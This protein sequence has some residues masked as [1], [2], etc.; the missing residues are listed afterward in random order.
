MIAFS[1][2]PDVPLTIFLMALGTGIFSIITRD[3]IWALC[4]MVAILIFSILCVTYI[5]PWP[6]PDHCVCNCRGY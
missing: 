5:G 6:F 3:V 2:F 1:L 4:I